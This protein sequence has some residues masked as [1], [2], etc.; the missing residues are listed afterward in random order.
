[1]TAVAW[2]GRGGYTSRRICVHAGSDTA[3]VSVTLGG[4]TKTRTLTGDA[5]GAYNNIYFDFD[6]LEQGTTYNWSASSDGVVC[7]S[8]TATTHTQGAA[9]FAYLSCLQLQ[10]GSCIPPMIV[11]AGCTDVLCLGDTPYADDPGATW[12]GVTWATIA[13]TPTFENWCLPFLAWHLNPHI[14]EMGRHVGIVRMPG[15][16]EAADNFSPGNAMW[17]NLSTYKQVLSAWCIGNN[18]SMTAGEIYHIYDI[19]PVSCFLIDTQTRKSAITDADSGTPDAYAKSLLGY[20]SGAFV[21]REQLKAWSLRSGIKLIAHGYR[22]GAELTDHADGWKSYQKEETHLHN[23]WTS[24]GISG[25][26]HAEGDFH[27]SSFGQFSSGP[28][29]C[30]CPAGVHVTHIIGAGYG[31]NMLWKAVGYEATAVGSEYAFGHVIAADSYVDGW[32]ITST[33]LRIPRGR[34]YADARECVQQ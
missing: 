17:A 9:N 31:T 22:L 15:D 4:V 26:F 20:D 12:W 23:Y 27:S 30:P 14:R 24:N 32:I 7:D 25:L 18:A 1:M 21:Q 11:A 34:L 8:G 28:S 16:H 3:T 6:G 29:M 33:G 2:V 5:V 10:S 13:T 19:G